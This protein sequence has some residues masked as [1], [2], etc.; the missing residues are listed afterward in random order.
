MAQQHNGYN[1]VFLPNAVE[2]ILECFSYLTPFDAVFALT[3]CQWWRQVLAR[4]SPSNWRLVAQIERNSVTDIDPKKLW[5]RNAMNVAAYHGSIHQMEYLHKL[6][7]HSLRHAMEFAARKGH[8]DAIQ[9]IRLALGDNKQLPLHV[10]DVAVIHGHLHIL[11]WAASIGPLDCCSML[12]QAA[13]GC[14]LHIMKW[15]YARNQWNKEFF[16]TSYT[17]I[18]EAAEE[19]RIDIL[20]WAKDIGRDFG[21]FDHCPCIWKTAADFDR[22]EVLQWALDNSIPCKN[23]AMAI[24]AGVNFP[25]IRDWFAQNGFDFKPSPPFGRYWNNV[26][27]F[28]AAKWLHDRGVSLTEESCIVAVRHGDLAWLQWCV[29]NLAPVPADLMET[30]V[31]CKIQSCADSVPNTISID[32]LR[33]LRNVLRISWTD[34]ASFEAIEYG[35]WQALEWAYGEEIRHP[36]SQRVMQYIYASSPHIPTLCW[37]ERFLAPESLDFDKIALLAYDSYNGHE[38]WDWLCT[39]KGYVFPPNYLSLI[40]NVDHELQNLEWLRDKGILSAEEFASRKKL[41]WRFRQYPNVSA[42]SDDC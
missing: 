19:G 10:L 5:S 18:N 40:E 15:L 38:V 2:I 37:L 16:M 8:L 3:V 14:Q 1:G 22:L 29:A 24:C 21:D 12:Q 25:R 42:D 7:G 17:L 9:W 20:Q 23:L 31:C 6:C 27:T 33:Y 35:N 28:E 34:S 32:I 4:R 41:C 39:E 30:A 26:T 11:Q 36:M 13:N